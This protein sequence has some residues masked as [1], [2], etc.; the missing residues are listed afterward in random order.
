MKLDIDAYH[1]RMTL[2]IY[3]NGRLCGVT[4]HRA[5]IIIIIIQHSWHHIPEGSY[6]SWLS[7]DS[8]KL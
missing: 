7:P 8:T 4:S 6:Y 2:V 3:E 1:V 5:I